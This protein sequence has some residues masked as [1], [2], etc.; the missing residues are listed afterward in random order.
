MHILKQPRPESWPAD[1]SDELGHISQLIRDVKG[2]VMV[3]TEA[4][5]DVEDKI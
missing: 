1:V 2:A 5:R 4:W 3:A